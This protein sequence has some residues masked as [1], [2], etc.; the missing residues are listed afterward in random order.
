MSLKT[1]FCVLFFPI[2][3]KISVT[4]SVLKLFFSVMRVNQTQY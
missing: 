3:K 1:K 2:D 4:S